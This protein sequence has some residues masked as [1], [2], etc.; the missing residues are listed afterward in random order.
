M[1]PK[2]PQGV[3][4][5]LGTSYSQFMSNLRVLWVLKV[6]LMD[7]NEFSWYLKIPEGHQGILRDLKGPHGAQVILKG[8]KGS[9]GALM[10]TQGQQE[11]MRD[12]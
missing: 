2:G 1:N 12:L 7:H 8:L 4:R 3:L 6:C 5:N 9:Y 11:V 10:N